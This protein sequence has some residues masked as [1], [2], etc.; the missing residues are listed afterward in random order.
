[1]KLSVAHRLL[2]W[3][4]PDRRDLPWKHTTDP[5]RIWLSEI[6]LQQTRV[7]QGR[8][9]YLRFVE[10]FPD[11]QALADAPVD[12]VLRLWEGLG[13]YSRARNLHAA[14]RQV[15]EESGGEFPRTAAGLRRLRGV[16]EYTA[17][18]IASFAYGEAIAVVDGNVYRV[19]ARLFGKATPIDSTAGRREF[20]ALAHSLLDPGRPGD[21][22]QAIMD[23]G[24]L[25]CTPKNPDCGSCPFAADCR[26]RLENRI[27]TLPAKAGKVRRRHRYFTYYVITDGHSLLIDRRHG[28][29]V[30][31]GL[32]QLPVT[33]SAAHAPAKTLREDELPWAIPPGGSG[34]WRDLGSARQV[35]SHQTIHARFAE[36]RLSALPGTGW[37]P[38]WK[39]VPLGNLDR[40]A[41]PRIVRRFLDGYAPALQEINRR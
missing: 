13:Y 10:R 9:Y 36:L 35:L 16:G 12:E 37:P 27:D 40:Y 17:A 26:A 4:D 6:I 19:L 29:D 25:V 23:F 41:F 18:A 22:N 38:G 20:A 24:A 32:Y 5:Y 30:W 31:K 15:V 39:A 2:E 3:Y 8:P 34:T 7:E 33:E 1:M 11:V 21:F 14:A 28:D